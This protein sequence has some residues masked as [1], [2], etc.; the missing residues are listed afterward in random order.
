MPCVL[1]DRKSGDPVKPEDTRTAWI[2]GEYDVTP[3]L[4]RTSVS[5]WNFAREAAITKAREGLHDRFACE[6][7]C[8]TD[9][10]FC[11]LDVRIIANRTGQIVR[12][13][14][15]NHPDSF[16]YKNGELKSEHIYLTYE[17]QAEAACRCE[18]PPR[19]PGRPGAGVEHYGPPLP[20]LGR[21]EPAPPGYDLGPKFK[22]GYPGKWGLGL[23]WNYKF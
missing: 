23:D 2:S 18:A 14:I 6:G 15:D 13:M 17:V 9:G 10:H 21:A 1:T 22:F 5:N 8:E 19:L 3:S 4:D 16:P 12:R 20:S 11:V 7:G